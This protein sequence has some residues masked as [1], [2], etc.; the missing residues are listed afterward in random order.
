MQRTCVEQVGS[1]QNVRRRLQTARRRAASVKD[2][3][4]GLQEEPNLALYER[5]FRHTQWVLALSGA[6]LGHLATNRKLPYKYRIFSHTTS[7]QPHAFVRAP[8]R[9]VIHRCLAD[10]WP[11]GSSAKKSYLALVF[12]RGQF[13]WCQ[14]VPIANNAKM[15]S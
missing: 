3:S 11:G 13:N 6:S 8:C 10:Q 9:H 2:Y 4:Y 7:T 12:L 1:R 5:P 15:L 14:L